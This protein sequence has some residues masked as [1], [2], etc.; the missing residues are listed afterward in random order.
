M[1]WIYKTL[2]Q[3]SKKVGEKWQAGKIAFK[4]LI[5]KDFQLSYY[6]IYHWNDRDIQ[7]NVTQPQK[8]NNSLL[9]GNS[10]LVTQ[11]SKIALQNFHICTCFHWW[12]NAEYVLIRISTNFFEQ[13]E[14]L[15]QVLNAVS[16][17]CKKS[18]GFV[19]IVFR[20][21]KMDIEKS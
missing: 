20:S 4:L 1:K 7:N 10:V 21:W 13:S 6:Y 19:T 8:R 11:D 18:L 3:L 15:L 14:Q 16:K 17:T 5:S 9:K 12:T 2:L